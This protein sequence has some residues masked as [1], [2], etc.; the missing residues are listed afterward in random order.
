MTISQALVAQKAIR[1]RIGDL[2][3]L[4]SEVSTRETFFGEPKK[5]IEPMF[6]VAAVDAY[7][8]YLKLKLFIL[9]SKVKEAN[10]IT[11]IGM[12]VDVEHLLR[13]LP[14]IENRSWQTEENA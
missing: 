8:S 3:R 11:E 5:Q 13:P 7:I 10:A 6:N 14:E 1:D 2:T 9:D 12:N 4:R